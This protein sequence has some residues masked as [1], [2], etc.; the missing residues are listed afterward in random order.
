M[1]E[2]NHTRRLMF[3]ILNLLLS[4]ILTKIVASSVDVDQ[5]LVFL[6]FSLAIMLGYGYGIYTMIRKYD[7]L[8]K[9]AVKAISDIGKE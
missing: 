3:A 7:K 2:N 8:V 6:L 9:D 1:I 4:F 5:L